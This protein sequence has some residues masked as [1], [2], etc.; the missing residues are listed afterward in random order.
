MGD[1]QNEYPGKPQFLRLQF[2]DFPG[3][4]FGLNSEHLQYRIWVW[5]ISEGTALTL[6]MAMGW[7]QT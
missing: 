4:D 7:Q 3:L 6:L 2:Q 5:V 1:N